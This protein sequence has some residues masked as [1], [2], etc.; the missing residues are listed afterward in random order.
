MWDERYMLR[1]CEP[2]GVVFSPRAILSRV[3]GRLLCVRTSEGEMCCSLTQRSGEGGPLMFVINHSERSYQRARV[4]TFAFTV[5]A[6]PRLQL[7][8]VIANRDSTL[9]C[10][11]S[12]RKLPVAP[13]RMRQLRTLIEV[14]P[15]NYFCIR[16]SCRVSESFVHDA[17]KLRSSCK[18]IGV[19][20]AE[21]GRR[22]SK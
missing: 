6:V 2:R 12:M 17:G 4:I 22:L 9:T 3:R 8:R 11:L 5:A 18:L 19:V 14:K 21:L 10:R 15:T 7:Q 1:A 16:A 13:R 20:E